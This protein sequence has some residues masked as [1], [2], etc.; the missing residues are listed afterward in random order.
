MT[1][2]G[3]ATWHLALLWLIGIAVSAALLVWH[4][5]SF[6]GRSQ[7]HEGGLSAFSVQPAILVIIA[8]I[9]VLCLVITVFWLRGK[10]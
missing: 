3:L 4:G 5:Q 9:V 7:A 6:R 1:I 10:T 8:L 2:R